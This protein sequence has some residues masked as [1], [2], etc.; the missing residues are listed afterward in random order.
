MLSTSAH[1]FIKLFFIIISLN[2]LRYY[3]YVN[4]RILDP[5]LMMENFPWPLSTSFPKETRIQGAASFLQ[6]WNSL[7]FCVISECSTRPLPLHAS[8]SSAV[9]LRS[10]FHNK[11]TAEDMVTQLHRSPLECLQLERR[12][13]SKR[14]ST[15]GGEKL[16]RHTAFV[17]ATSL[18]V[19][20]DHVKL[21]KMK[22]AQPLQD[23]FFF[24]YKFTILCNERSLV[25]VFF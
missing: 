12:G 24:N 7:C 10:L 14:S 11:A 21:G 22:T 23:H 1:I 19:F 9:I 18:D 2:I 20:T 3:Y 17:A 16:R 4:D 8:D 25:V 15:W 13:H 5:L 6:W